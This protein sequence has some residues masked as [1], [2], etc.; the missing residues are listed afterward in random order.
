MKYWSVNSWTIP[1]QFNGPNSDEYLNYINSI[2]FTNPDK[3]IIC[4]QTEWEFYN[5][6]HLNKIIEKAKKVNKKITI[7]VAIPNLNIVNLNQ[8]LRDKGISEE[9]F[10]I[11]D[12]EFWGLSFF[13]ETLRETFGC[14]KES[15]KNIKSINDVF[16]NYSNTQYK[17]HFVYFNK[18]PH[19]HR[20]KL[21][22]VIAKH[23]L[24]DYSA[25]SWHHNPDPS[26]YTFKQFDGKTRI[27][28]Q[29]YT[30]ERQDQYWM[31]DIYYESFFQLI[32]ESTLKCVFVTEKTCMPLLI[33]KP[34]IIAGAMGIHEYLVSLGFKLYD[35]LFD[36]S[37]DSETNDDVRYEKIAKQV[38][39]ITQIPLDQLNLFHSKIIDKINYN[40]Q[41]FLKLAVDER[42][43]PKTAI[44]LI[45]YHRE[46]G[47]IVDKW[48]IDTEREVQ[49]VKKRHNLEV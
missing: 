19:L 14:Y 36:Y 44:E 21:V 32:S 35:E 27:I 7:V 9:D 41:L 12:F 42:T 1:S 38:E 33:G 26:L 24:I 20:C 10:K 45:K 49:Y 17:H 34:F 5:I 48:L 8:E 30:Y 23:N 29:R 43:I 39:K 37:F 2:E 28:D 46:T 40:R 13:R 11:F 25:M 22:D 47:I 18:I 15:L 3:I 16:M 4:S 6:P 31:P